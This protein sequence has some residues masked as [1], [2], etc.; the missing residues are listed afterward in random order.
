MRRCGYLW[1]ETSASGLLPDFKVAYN[2]CESSA[3]RCHIPV[4]FI[5]SVSVQTFLVYIYCL[6]SLT[7]QLEGG[8]QDQAKS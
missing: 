7:S 2:T 5:N 6:F 4:V 8:T 3:L 1:Q